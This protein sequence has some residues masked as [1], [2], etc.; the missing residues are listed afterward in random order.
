MVLTLLALGAMPLGSSAQQPSKVWRIGMLETISMAR[1][2]ANLNAFLKGM[3]ELGYVEG[4]NFVIDYRSAGGRADQF[5]ELAT[6]LVRGKVDLIVT[7]GTPATQAATKA[8][9][10][11][12]VVATAIGE[13]LLFAASLAQP[14]GNVTGL[15]PFTTDLSA[16]RVELLR[17]LVP[18]VARI[19]CLINMSN[20]AA[21]PA[22]KE[23][24]RAARSLGVQVE[25]FDVRRA[26]DLER[27]FEAAVKQRANAIIVGQDGLMQANGKHIVELATKHR[28]PAIY[29]ASDYVE[30]GGLIGY[31]VSYPD[32]YRRAASY[33]DKI[34]K[35]TKPGDLP[36]EQPAKFDLVINR[37]AAKGLGITIPQALLARADRVIE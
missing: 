10:T 37:N 3:Q 21:P 1:N 28:L 26:S 34:M 25:L 20:A 11:I 16:K 6:E 31:G 29:S 33:V 9:R 14:G 7:R 23:I 19:A 18:G 27:A 12:P 30:D 35:G 36:I 22:W 24:E 15:T 8:T 32:L 17:E 2:A 4:R 13:P 5:P